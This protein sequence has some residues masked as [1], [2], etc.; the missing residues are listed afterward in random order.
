M[1]FSCYGDQER[2]LDV[3]KKMVDETT[4]IGVL[5]PCVA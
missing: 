5:G 4:L 3:I 1:L 2:V